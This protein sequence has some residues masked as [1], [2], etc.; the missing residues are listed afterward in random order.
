MKDTIDLPGEPSLS[1]RSL[2]KQIVGISALAS[3][4]GALST[5]IACV[6]APPETKKPEPKRNTFT[7]TPGKP[8]TLRGVN[9]GGWLVLEKWI[10]PSVFTNL[11][12]HDEYTL[13][14]ELGAGARKHLQEHRKRY[15]T[16]AD[17]AWIAAHGMN[18][19]RLP[20]GYWVLG[21]EPP[22]VDAK[23]ELD[24]AFEWAQRQGL[25]VVLDLHGAPGS[26]N[27]NDHSGRSGPLEWHT[28]PENIART[29]QVLEDLAERYKNQDSLIALELLNEPRWDVPM[30]ILKKFYQD[31]YHRVRKHLTKDRVAIMYHDGF[32]PNDWTGFMPEPEY[33]NV[34]LDTHIYQ[35]FTD[36]DR[37][38]PAAQQVQRAVV[39]HAAQLDR[40]Q[41]S[42]WG[43]VGEW[44]L[45]LPGESY[46][47]LSPV[48]ANALKRAYAGA[49][50]LSYERA[51]C[52]WFF[53]TYKTETSPDWSLRDCIE[54]GWMPES[55]AAV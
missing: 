43:T 9:L 12:A 5:P 51:S 33:S 34:I 41:K 36:D 1:R 7:R 39:D 37:K 44:S 47:G 3:G 15:I 46:A 50:L 24:Q 40:I 25:Y 31:A 38:R 22:Y 14:Q 42:V 28:K 6:A 18:A 10:T 2:M 52:G 54:R 20:V 23:A 26:Q 11:K 8:I 48:A 16:E 19:V 30:D 29:L 27:G 21:G 35:C 13:S 49:Q 53:W 4:A 32:R 17:F 45:G 55:F